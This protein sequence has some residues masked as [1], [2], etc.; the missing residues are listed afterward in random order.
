MSKISASFSAFGWT[1]LAALGAIAG[2]ALYRIMPHLPNL[3]PVGAMFVLGG[4]YLG[5]NLA[6]MAAPFLGLVISDTVLNLA[7]DGRA[8]HPGRLFDYLAFALVGLAARWMANK[9]LAA[10]IG[11][12]VGAPV[13]FF[14]ISN[15]GVWAGGTMYPRTA[16][17]LMDCYTLALP[18]FR[19]TLYGDWLFA[20]AGL[21][22]LEALRSR[23]TRS[24]AALA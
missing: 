19:G 4:L 10:R 15:L 17:G 16:Q 8:I 9:P 2:V 5:R 18:F 22:M 24:A 14:L 7:Y 6:W 3:T 23:E 12:V 21:L 11:V 13:A 1:R 20:G